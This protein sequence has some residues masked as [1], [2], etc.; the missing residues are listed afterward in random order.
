MG[1]KGGVVKAS[2]NHCYKQDLKK[3]KVTIIT[4]RVRCQRHCLRTMGPFSNKIRFIGTQA[5]KYCSGQSDNQ[6]VYRVSIWMIVYTS[7]IR[8]A[9]RTFTFLPG[10]TETPWDFI[11]LLWIACNVE[12][13]SFYFSSFPFNLFAPR[14]AWDTKFQKEFG[15]DS[16]RL[17]YT[18]LSY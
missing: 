10:W 9:K 2:K 18:V 13:R 17:L 8:W 12:L 5:L 14:W 15:I 7:W 11:M 6:D 4:S 3:I 16:Q 1:Y